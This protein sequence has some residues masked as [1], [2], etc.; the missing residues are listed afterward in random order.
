M[1]LVGMETKSSGGAPATK[2]NI[3]RIAQLGSQQAAATRKKMVKT[4]L[5]QRW[6]CWRQSLGRNCATARAGRMGQG[7]GDL[8]NSCQ[9]EMNSFLSTGHGVADLPP[10]ARRLRT[11]HKLFTT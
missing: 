5:N 3:S 1:N 11:F 4:Q 2:A 6:G 9:T 10:L 8:S 7:D